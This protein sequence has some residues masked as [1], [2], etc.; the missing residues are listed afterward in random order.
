[1]IPIPKRRLIAKATYLSG[2]TIMEVAEAFNISRSTVK[3]Y[4][5][6]Y[7]VKAPKM[8]VIKVPRENLEETLNVLREFDVDFELTTKQHELIEYYES[9][10]N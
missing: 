4:R 3:K 5:K 7:P 2:L 8:A 1:M 9:K 6:E 10:F